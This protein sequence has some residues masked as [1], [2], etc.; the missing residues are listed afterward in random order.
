MFKA[1]GTKSAGKITDEELI[2]AKKLRAHIKL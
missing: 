2:V 1:S